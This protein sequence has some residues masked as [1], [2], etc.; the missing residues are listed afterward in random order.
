MTIGERTP[1]HARTDILQ[2]AKDHHIEEAKKIADT[3]VG[4]RD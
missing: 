1:F 3:L 4:G 2:L